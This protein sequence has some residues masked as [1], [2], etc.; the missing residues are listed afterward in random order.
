MGNTRR[1]PPGGRKTSRGARTRERILD[2]ASDLVAQEPSATLGLERIARA[3]GVAKSSV[4]WHFGNKEQLY[5]EVA[6]RWFTEFQRSIT[7]DIGEERELRRALPL[8]LRGY[9]AFLATR[10]EA[11]VV[12]FTLLFGASRGGELHRRIAGMYREF[13]RGI[14]EVTHVDG[15][16][17]SETDAALIVAVLDGVF[18]QGFIDPDGFE[19]AA[20]FA[21]LEA[22]LPSWAPGPGEAP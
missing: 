15:Q 13:R 20:A 4:L 7:A 2:A 1:E 17:L 14:V 8:L 21:R 16:R 5:L 22:L 10:P 18:V 19:P 9:S 12:L 3:A 6:D 11:N